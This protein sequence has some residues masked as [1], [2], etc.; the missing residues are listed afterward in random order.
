VGVAI[1]APTYFF[2]NS[3]FDVS[4]WPG[5]FNVLTILGLSG[6]FLFAQLYRYRRVSNQVQCQQT[7]WVVFG[8][9]IA[10]VVFLVGSLYS[11]IFPSLSQPG[12][13]YSFAFTAAIGLVLLA[14][15]LSI[16][17]A[18]LRYRLWDVDVLINRTLVYG[19]L[20]GML[21]LVYTGL[22][23]TLQ[24]L[25]RGLTGGSQLALVG[26]TLVTAALIQ[27]LRRR[28]QRAIDRRFYRRKYDAARIVATF[29]ETLRGEVDLDELSEQLVAVVEETMQPTHVWLWLR[30]TEQRSRRDRET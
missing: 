12:S 21:A 26:S 30:K 17:I 2:P 16:G 1:A 25:L 14:I 18:I 13:L 20:T 4:T 3:P 22:A 29:S 6:T 5:G 23:V 27:P 15:P 8:V 11:L 28:I 19:V 7:K 24:F 10:L 9:T